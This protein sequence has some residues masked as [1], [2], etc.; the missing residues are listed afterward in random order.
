MLKSAIF[1]CPKYRL[2]ELYGLPGKTKEAG[3]SGP[4][5]IKE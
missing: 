1:I 4:G 5:W 3:D 2:K